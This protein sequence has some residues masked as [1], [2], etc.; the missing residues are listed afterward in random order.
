MAA[1]RTQIYL[2]ADQRR[3]LDERARQERKTLAEVIREAVDRYLEDQSPRARQ[4]VLDTTFG[5]LPSLE[6]PP[7]EEW[8]RSRG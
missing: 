5:A 8:D 6:I 7:R 2:T 1:Q 4:A 3:L